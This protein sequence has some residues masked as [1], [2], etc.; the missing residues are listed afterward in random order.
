MSHDGS[1]DMVLL[2]SQHD[3]NGGRRL[4]RRRRTRRRLP[5]VAKEE[6]PGLP[7]YPP[8]RRRR[9]GN[10]GQAGGSTSTVVGPE[11][12][13]DA[14]T[15]AGDMSGVVLAPETTAVVASQQRANPE[16]TDDASALTK[17][18]LGISLVPEITVHSVPDATS[19]SSA[20]QQVP[21][22]FHPVPFRFSFDPPSDPALVSAFVRAYPDFPGYHMWSTWDRLTAVSTSGPA[23]SEEE[24]DPDVSWN[25]FGL[26]DPGAMRDFMSACDHCLSGCSDDGH[27]LDNE[28]CDP[29]HECYHIDQEDHDGENHLGMPG[30]DDALAPAS[31]V[32]I[33]RELAVVQVPAGGQDTQLEQLREM[34]AKLDEK[35][36]R[37][38]QLRQNIEQEWAGRAL[39]GG[40]RH[41]ARDVQHRIVD[42]ARAGLPPAFSGAGQNLAAAAMLLRTMPEPSTTEGRRIQGELEGLQEDAVVRQAESSA[43]RRRGDPSEHRATPSRRMREATVHTERTRGGTPAAPDRLGD[44][45]HRRDRR[46]QLEERVRRGYHP[47][48]GGRYDSEE[49]QSPSPKPPGP[50]VFSQAIRRAPFPAQFRAPTTIT[51][52][53]GETRPELWL[54]DYRL[55]CQLGGTDDDNLII[56]NLPLFL[57]NAARAWLEHLPPAQI[58]DWDDLVKAFVGNFQGTYVRP[59]NSWDLRS[60][61]QQRRGINARVHLAIFEAAHRAAQHHR[62]GRHRG[63]PRRHHLP[64]PGEQTGAQDSHQGERIDGHR[65]QVRL[66]SGGGQS[67]LP[68]RQEASGKT[69]G[70]RPRGVRPAWHE[71]GQEEGASKTRRR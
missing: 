60:C 39:A 32:E 59:G 67:H 34:Q 19:L 29:T 21:S 44:E 58:F 50:R 66:W 31:R 62:L 43:S 6:H 49:D 10:H 30:S 37:L 33:P 14:G 3:N 38:V 7:R 8:R 42:D 53:S 56:R 54:A 57:S 28:G 17:D 15:P 71:E 24:D 26:R 2:P 45:Q 5:P 65:H 25:F 35:A 27:S 23:G 70:R 47:R 63:I 1:Y 20:N 22:V 4:A 69:E 68:E 36:R 64:R 55:A 16:R 11:R 9:R 61:R 51:K 46:A 41:R 52:Y 12:V 18:L 40:A 13:D 48:R